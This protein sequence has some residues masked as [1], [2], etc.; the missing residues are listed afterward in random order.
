MTSQK[1]HVVRL[2]FVLLL[3]LLMTMPSRHR[4]KEPSAEVECRAGKEGQDEEDEDALTSTA[5]RGRQEG[6]PMLV[7]HLPTQSARESVDATPAE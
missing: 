3:L 5:E 7:V 1:A 4:F 6:T 2:L